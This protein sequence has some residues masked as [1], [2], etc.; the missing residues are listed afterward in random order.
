MDLITK[1]ERLKRVKALADHATGNEKKAALAA[2]EKLKNI[3]EI[4]DDELA[5]LKEIRLT[6][7]DSW[8][9]KLLIQCIFMV[10]GNT[11]IGTIKRKKSIWVKCTIAEE[12]EI[13]L[14]YT[15]YKSAL[16]KHLEESYKAFLV[17]NQIYPDDT[18]RC[19]P[20]NT[21]SKEPLTEEE[22]RI[23]KIAKQL[24][25]TQIPRALLNS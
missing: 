11:K 14:C 22:R 17:V 18:V 9:Y 1:K 6:Y 15:I 7:K 4:S 8:E 24:N 23:L 16:K 3:Y 13:K 12:Q 5:E 20:S 21:S 19:K 2:Y 10:I 25:K